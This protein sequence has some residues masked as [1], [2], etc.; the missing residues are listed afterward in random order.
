MNTITDKQPRGRRW[1][2]LALLLSVVL[3]LVPELAIYAVAALAKARG[4]QVDEDR[5]CLIMGVR[6]S[7]VVA[8]MLRA[9]IFVARYMGEYG[10][11]VVWLGWC[12]LTITLGWR[13]LVS[14]L[15]LAFAIVL[16]FALLPYVGPQQSIIDLGSSNCPLSEGGV[17][18]CMIFGDDI[19]SSTHGAV[20]TNLTLLG[21]LIS[22]SSFVVYM[23]TMV[24]IRL[25]AGLSK[26]QNSPAVRAK[27]T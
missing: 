8:E 19:G 17:G 2:R 12:Y 24:V 10:L 25:C 13:S 20:N 4:C 3:P 27:E 16:I 11:A 7:N 18:R 9:G 23:I 6:A 15:S 22:V 14:R 5:V 21:A 1:W 26:R